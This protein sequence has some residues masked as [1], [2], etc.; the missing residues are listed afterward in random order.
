MLKKR[1]ASNIHT[2][3]KAFFMRSEFFILMVILLISLLLTLQDSTFISVNNII[4]MLGTFSFSAMVSIPLAFVLIAKLRDMSI[5]AVTGMLGAILALLMK[6]FDLNPFFAL[7]I[8]MVVG[9]LVGFLNSLLI[10]NLR[11]SAYIVTLAMMY[12]CRGVHQVLAQARSI[13]GLPSSLTSLAGVKLFGLPLNIYALLLLAVLAYLLLHKTN[14]GKNV[15]II[16]N[17]STIAKTSGIA[18]ER[19]QRILY[20]ITG[21]VCAVSAFFLCITYRAANITAGTGW[22]FEV[23]A[24][25]ILGGCSLYGGKG[26]VAGALLGMLL[27]TV[28][29]Y[30][31][32]A[33]RMNTSG[34]QI[35]ITGAI[36]IVSVVVDVTREKKLK[37]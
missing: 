12:I 23:T 32:Q 18:V 36:L 10:V 9:A 14:F 37:A 25:C 17:N 16:G 7:F 19:T 4:S 34:Y 30:A 2:K 15:F 8:V 29:R 27:M 6:T 33:L 35:L 3:L 13:T 24:G 28:I 1:N 21:C 20:I 31:L 5:G 26:S 11:I 22:E